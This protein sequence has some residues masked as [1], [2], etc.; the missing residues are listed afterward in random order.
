MSLVFY[1]SP[2]SSAVP[3]QWALEELG[4]P[5]EKVVLDLQKQEQRKPEFLKLNPNGKVPLLVH[6]G[7]P[8]FESIAILMHLGETY[9]VDKK[10]FP[11]PGLQRAEAFKWL[12][13]LNVSVGAAISRFFHNT[14]ERIPKEQ[15]NDKAAEAAKAEAHALLKILDGAL[16]GKSYLVGDTF[17]LV[18]VQASSWC[19]YFTHF[20]F[21]LAPYKS[22]TAYTARCMS[23]PKA[24]AA[25][26]V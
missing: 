11:A 26:G 8:I 17:T 21:D 25:L 24:K 19:W 16:E 13:W 15:H 9:G 14:S 6:D 18:D 7:V 3:V 12:A 4:V 5:Y 10:L 2:M 22:I 20:G 1:T 23:R